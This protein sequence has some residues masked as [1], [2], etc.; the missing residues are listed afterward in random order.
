VAR[1]GA[2]DL[3]VGELLEHVAHDPI[4]RLEADVGLNISGA[5]PYNCMTTPA[6]NSSLVRCCRPGLSR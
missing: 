2:D 3:V 6:Q 5:M 1:A 4:T